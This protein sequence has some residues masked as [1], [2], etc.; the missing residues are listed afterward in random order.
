M[1]DGKVLGFDYMDTA[2]PAPLIED[3]KFDDEANAL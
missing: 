1:R 2:L 3:K